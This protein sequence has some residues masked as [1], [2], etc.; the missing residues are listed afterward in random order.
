MHG[1]EDV[2]VKGAIGVVELRDEPNLNALRRRFV[3]LGVF[4]RPFGRVVYLTPAFSIGLPD[5]RQ[6]MG[7]VITAVREETTA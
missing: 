1:V 7:A 5:L 3:E 4:V 6:L 2:R